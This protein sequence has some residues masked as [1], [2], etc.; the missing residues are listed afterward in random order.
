MDKLMQYQEFQ[1][2]REVAL[3]PEIPVR[4]T[5]YSRE[6]DN[7]NRLHD[8]WKNAKIEAGRWLIRSLAEA[9]L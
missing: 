2:W 8:G 1:G 3:L 5:V 9:G 6:L 4:V 7:F